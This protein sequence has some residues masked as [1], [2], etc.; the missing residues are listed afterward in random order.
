M[1]FLI[2]ESGVPDNFKL[3]TSKRNEISQL[4]SI[5]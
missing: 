5:V 1:F 2:D 4:M 3:T